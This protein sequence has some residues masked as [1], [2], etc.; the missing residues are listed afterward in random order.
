MSDGKLLKPPRQ[1]PES[2]IR[3]LAEGAM[4][5]AITLVLAVIS[6]YIPVLN[7]VA[8]F[9]FPAPLALLVLR[10]GL[11]Y[12]LLSAA[13]IF[14]LSAMLLGLPHAVYLFI[15]YGFMGLF[16]GWCFR[17]DKKAAFAILGGVLISC[18]S[19]IILL[20]FPKYILGI[21]AD[22]MREMLVTMYRDFALMAEQQGTSSMLGGMTVEE[23]VDFALKYLPFILLLFAMLLSFACYALMGR[24]LRRLGYDIPKL[25]PFSDWR[26][27][28]RLLWLLII[29]LFASSL[30]ERM[31]NELLTQIANNLLAALQIIFMIYGLAVLIWV[32]ARNKVAV[33]IR[34]V[35][36]LFL[37][38]L[39]SGM[40]V[41]LIGVFDPLFNFRGLIEK[42]AK[43]RL[44]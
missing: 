23:Y 12:G 40:L 13:S 8:Q 31:D 20:L 10:R 7:I 33:I 29:S 2:N 44:K 27:D 17:S 24:L 14:L 30:G 9:L 41:V 32:F 1:Q 22:S 25:P 38:Q 43:T 21:S 16:F 6:L 19:I 28:W 18:A 3:A 34:I 36:I 26:L 5:T 4:L 11:K 35:A 39:L 15:L 37:L 42:Y